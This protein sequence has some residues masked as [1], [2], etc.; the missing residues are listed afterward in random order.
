M[1]RTFSSIG[2]L[3]D[4]VPPVDFPDRELK[5]LSFDSRRIVDPE[6]T[7]F[8]ALDGER[9]GHEFV[10]EVY[11]SGVRVFIVKKGHRLPLLPEAWII[12][13]SNPLLALQKIAGSYRQTL[14]YPLVGITGSNGKTVVKEWLNHL[15]TAKMKIGRSPKSYNSQLGLPLSIWQLEPEAALGLI[16]AGISRSGEMDKL[17]DVLK[18]EFGILTGIGSAHDEGFPSRLDKTL[19]KLSLFRHAKWLVYPYEQEIIREALPLWKEG[20]PIRKISWGTHSAADLVFSLEEGKQESTIRWENNTFHVPFNDKASLENACTCLAFL[21]AWGQDPVAYQEQFSG[22]PGIDMRLQLLQGQFQSR[23]INDAYSADLSSLEI[24]LQFMKKQAGQMKKTLILSS[25]QA[26][27]GPDPQ[28]G[29]LRALLEA[30]QI[31]RLILIGKDFFELR[32]DLGLPAICF[33]STEQFLQQIDPQH[34][35]DE[36]VLIKGRR[37]HHFERIVKLLEAQVHETQLEIDLNALESNYRVFRNKVTPDVRVM[38]M[39][40]AQGYGSGSLEIARV[41]QNAGAE[42]LAVAYTD[43]GIHLRRN[44]VAL[45]IMV[46]NAQRDSLAECIDYELE[47]V[48]Y[49]FSFLEY[50]KKTLD[51]TGL[52]EA[53]IH[54]EFD[55]GMHRLG[56][57]EV[58]A[59]E[60]MRAVRSDGRLA[61]AS[62]F[63]HLAASDEGQHD[64]YTQMQFE[65]FQR[66]RLLIQGENFHPLFHILNTAGILRFPEMAL[67]M[68]RPGIGL[69]GI[70]AGD[71]LAAELIPVATLKARLSQL[72]M[73]KKG[74]TVGYGRKGVLKEDTLVGVVSIGYADGFRRCLSNGAG[75]VWIKGHLAPVIG[76][77]CMDMTM[78]NLNGIDCQAGDPVEIFGRNLPIETLARMADTIPYEIITGISNRVNRLYF[79]E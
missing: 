19:E 65:R 72:R 73:L 22:L 52:T 49:T 5:H 3:F 21:I 27:N 16:E 2:A 74:E 23:L 55:T 33:E 66:I 48:V 20:R 61:V 1:T 4:S 31:N 70:D 44:G 76:N 46:M 51:Q 6:H 59:L 42:Y 57:Q 54:L 63:S 15:L 24:A 34:F 79:R 64:G 9:D 12:P 69:Y 47:P 13:T 38:A 58:D 26:E 75:K 45:P 35:R 36:M 37:D 32:P 43:E 78:V 53:K 10:D 8:F 25:L 39:V 67:D 68:I 50:L 41:L 11:Q 56:F 29:S 18:P 77:V 7:L 71:G 30:Y 28:W 60:L 14:K 17:E 62:V 40:K